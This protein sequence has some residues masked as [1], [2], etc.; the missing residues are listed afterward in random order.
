MLSF[1]LACFRSVSVS[2]GS[3]SMSRKDSLFKFSSVAAL[4][5]GSAD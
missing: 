1:D 2:S 5:G 3:V 4:G